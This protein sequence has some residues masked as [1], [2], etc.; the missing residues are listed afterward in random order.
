M[1]KKNTQHELETPS[2]DT[3]YNRNLRLQSTW[4][5]ILALTTMSGIDTSTVEKMAHLWQLRPLINKMSTK[6]S[7]MPQA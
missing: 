6:G 3:S 2:S 7:S 1:Y 5:S 4:L